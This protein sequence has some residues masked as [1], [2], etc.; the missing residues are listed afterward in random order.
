MNTRAF[1]LSALIAGVVMALLGSLPLINFCN[2]FLCMW[3][4]GSA[5]L[6][7]FLYRRFDSAGPALSVGQGAILG[8][9]AGVIGGV[10]GAIIEAIFASS[11]LA[12]TLELMRSQPSLQPF[13]DAY[14]GLIRGGGFGFLGK[15]FNI[16]IYAAFGAIGGII[17]TAL[18]WKAPQ[19][20]ASA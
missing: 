19:S 7:V 9:A 5:I 11:T 4:W 6:A 20:P 10:I 18:I 17:A 1:T 14:S 13:V 8:V 15:L 16:V 12:G 3:V 2:C